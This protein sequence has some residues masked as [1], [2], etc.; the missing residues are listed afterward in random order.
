MK[1][2]D[3]GRPHTDE[4]PRLIV[5][6]APYA[7]LMV[8]ARRLIVLVNRGTEKLFG[9]SRDELIGEPVEKLVPARYRDRHAAQVE[10][11]VAAPKARAMG[12]REL[13]G[14]RKDGTDVPIEIGLNPLET[15]DGVFTLASII[16]VSER[17][18]A[19]ERFRVVVEAAPSAMLMVDGERRITL[20]NRKTED[21]F[22]YDRKELV[23]QRIETLLPERFRER[24]AGY[25][26]SFLGAP[27]ARPMGAGRE[28]FGRR[29]DGREIP[30]EIGL[31]PI[32]TPDGVY[33]LASVI[34][35]TERKRAEAAQQRLAAIVENSEDAIVSTTL[36]GAITSW[37]RGAERLFGY[38]ADE[39]VGRPASML[40]PERLADEEV[41]VMDRLR[42]NEQIDHFET[43]RRRKDGT[44]VDVSE[45]V[46]PVRNGAGELAGGS[47][48]SRDITELKRRDTELQRSN[49]ELEQFAYVASHDLQEPLRMVA[50]YTELLAERYKGKLD[51][52]ADKYIY[53]ASDGAR[54]MQRL[55]T[56]L[57]AYSR[58]GSQ[59]KPLRPVASA[60]VLMSVLQSIHPLLRDA[61][62]TV[63][64]EGLPIVFADEVQ[65][66]QLFQNLVGN[67][68][69]FRAEA[70]PRVTI[71]AVQQGDRWLFS[72]AD[73]GIGIDMKYADRIFQMFQR[74]HE[75][76]R[77]EGSGIGL[78]I[79]KRIVERHGGRIW[80]ESREG[81][82]TTF[83]FT[84]RAVPRGES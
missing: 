66:R 42:R 52:K 80:V 9:F 65:L 79:A 36:D 47:R 57:L 48:I 34:D 62:A 76:G 21:L 69:K 31:N 49:A 60:D 10:G 68:I 2:T 72:V 74:L 20:V 84:L 71:R 55:V 70:A 29:K 81:H 61:A 15:P 82:G 39:A 17:R 27:T 12:G 13:V 22:G 51:A 56:D 32:E 8:D 54:R 58:V 46:S 30:I 18:R 3:L 59:G 25:V 6:A 53:Y 73:N 50:N 16:D 75:L 64:H 26:K 78:S 67:A 11:F 35:I 40:V 63:E 43:V 77:Y 38:S 19:D 4:W 44:E 5:E 14:V 41:R 33:T 7:M 28:L 1:P 83:H 23:G 37:N 24:H 45:M